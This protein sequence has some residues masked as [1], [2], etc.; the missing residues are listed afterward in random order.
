MMRV[1]FLHGNP[2]HPSDGDLF[3]SFLSPNAD[4]IAVDAYSDEW[5]LDIQNSSSRVMVVAHSWGCY[6]LMSLMNLIESKVERVFL[7]NPY[8]RNESALSNV[9]KGLLSVPLVG[10]ILV[11]MNHK[12]NYED[13]F[14]NM[15]YPDE[16]ADASNGKK[17]Y[18]HKLNLLSD[19]NTWY[20]AI[21]AK[22]LQQEK[23]LDL[24]SGVLG[25]Y[26][27]GLQDKAM[28][29]DIQK[30]EIEKFRYL[31]PRWLSKSGHGALWTDAQLI[32][33]D[34]NAMIDKIGYFPESTIK[35]NVIGF[36]EKHVYENPN[37]I[38]L[39]WVN[40]ED[41]KK[42][43][44]AVSDSLPHQE[45]SFKKF[46]EMISK[47]AQGLK[48]IGI[49]K[50]DRVII[51]L[52]MSLEMYVAMFATQRIGAI[53][54][55][56]DSWA[57]S[58]HLGAS[59]DCVQPKAM[60]SFEMAFQLVDQVPEFRSMPIRILY[61][62]GEKMTHRFDELLNHSFS[63]I[64]A[65]ESE[66][67]ALIT[68]TTGSTGKPKG[69]NRSH[70]FLV[71]QHH[72]LTHVIPFTSYD[73]DMPAFP[74]FS[75]NSLAAGVTTILPAINLAQPSNRDSAILATQIMGEKLSCTT[76]A[77]SMLV[78]LSRFCKE[79]KIVL[80]HLRRVVTGGA[81]IS[82]DDV[83]AFYDVA[84]QSEL[85]ILYGSTE[86]EPMAHIEGH[87][88]LKEEVASDPE[89]VELGVN[90][91]H[92]SE[93]L[94]Y[95]FIKIVDGPIVLGASAWSDIEI[96]YSEVKDPSF[97][98]GEFICTGDHVCREYYNNKEAFKSAKILDD[99]NKVWH[100]TGDLGYLDTKKNL[101]IVGRTNNAI[102]RKGRY[103]FPVQAE[104]LLKRLDFTY[105]CAYLGLELNADTQTVVAIELKQE[106]DSKTF[107]FSKAR[108]E[109]QRV[110]RKNDIPADKILF[111]T[112]IPMDPRHHSK[113]E[114]AVLRKM[115]TDSPEVIVD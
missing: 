22:K 43:T 25:Y 2:G 20:K 49:E 80:S 106:F 102:L 99:K 103:H 8:L 67:P 6:R 15:I 105:R 92:I 4:F 57:R 59:A 33:E 115:I 1:Y 34:I 97:L 44:G 98:V 108:N 50:G 90:V 73:K 9:A 83:R 107:D 51:F 78:G 91:G 58:H 60:I 29:L 89:I 68:F 27:M 55:F 74:I 47:F 72:A 111:V 53:A 100:R 101:W 95:K 37:G 81:P 64:T 48:S 79:Q 112:A 63:E 70:R 12:K 23:P 32:A 52:P 87:E 10:D 31:K 69:A 109:I 65:V 54:V 45:I 75:L 94:E 85:W 36:I 11:K 17:H 26:Y 62:P 38:A 110:F 18:V 14:R 28:N 41:L 66:F 113:V 82:K 104:V 35:N 3:K 21:K 77:P 71:A 76:L 13:Y 46:E 40:T 42:W 16:L 30:L 5:V 86:A 7:I 24:K 56:L 84:P 114:Y 88:M 93:D 61:G 39:K 96:K 19:P